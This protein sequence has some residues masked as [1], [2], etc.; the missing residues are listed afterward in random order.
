VRQ[1]TPERAAVPVRLSFIDVMPVTAV[2]KIFKP[3]LR[4]DAVR[5]MVEGLLAELV[6][7]DASVAVAVNAHAVH[8]QMI[9]VVLGGVAAAQRQTIDGLVHERLDPLVMR[10]EISWR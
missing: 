2:G 9:S 5:L 8:G 1:R 10:H 3:A 7:P 6:P 4:L